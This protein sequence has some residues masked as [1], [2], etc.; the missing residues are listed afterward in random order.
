MINLFRIGVNDKKQ[1]QQQKNKHYVILCFVCEKR[2]GSGDSVHLLIRR[3]RCQNSMYWL[4][5]SINTLNMRF[6]S[7]Y[8]QIIEI[9]VIT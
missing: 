8:K 3:D 1:Q 6:C 5:I 4:I 2:R 7:W 9:V